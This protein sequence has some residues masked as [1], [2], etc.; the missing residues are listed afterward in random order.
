MFYGILF[1]LF[2]LVCVIFVLAD[3]EERTWVTGTAKIIDSCFAG[4]GAGVVTYAL[5]QYLTSLF[6]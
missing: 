1:V 4:I 6:N 3:K 2:V 5:A